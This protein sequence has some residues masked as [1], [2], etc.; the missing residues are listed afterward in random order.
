MRKQ[1]GEE[2][3]V[4]HYIAENKSSSRIDAIVKVAVDEYSLKLT[5][6][7]CHMKW[8]GEVCILSTRVD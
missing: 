8:W 4:W 1:S 2:A 3:A 6:T 5:L 7:N